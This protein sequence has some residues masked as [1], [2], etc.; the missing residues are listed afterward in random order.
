MSQIEPERLNHGI[1]EEKIRPI[2]PFWEEFW[3]QEQL[4]TDPRLQGFPDL[5]K[6]FYINQTK[7]RDPSMQELM[8]SI[9]K[10]AYSNYSPEEAHQILK[11]YMFSCVLTQYNES[12]GKKGETMTVRKKE[13]D[14][15]GNP[16]P[17]IVH[18][19]SM[20]IEAM[21]ESSANVRTNRNNSKK[22][23][24]AVTAMA[25]SGHDLVEDCRMSVEYNDE[26]GKSKKESISGRTILE[27]IRIEFPE[28]SEEVVDA[29]DSVTKYENLPPGLRKLIDESTLKAYLEQ[30]LLP[31]AGRSNLS[32]DEKNKMQK[33][34]TKAI[35]SLFKARSTHLLAFFQ[36]RQ[37]N[38]VISNTEKTE[39]SALRLKYFQGVVRSIYIKILD[40]VNNAKTGISVA[41]QIRARQLATLARILG[42]YKQSD[43]LMYLLADLKD[44]PFPQDKKIASN[45]E[46]N[47]SLYRTQFNAFFENFFK[48]QIG[49]DISVYIGPRIAFPEEGTVEPVPQAI[50]MVPSENFTDVFTFME[51]NT[52]NSELGRIIGTKPPFTF[53]PFEGILE[54]TTRIWGREGVMLRVL[55][56]DNKVVFYIRILEDKPLLS[57]YILNGYNPQDRSPEEKMFK[58]L[59]TIN[60]PADIRL[61]HAGLFYLNPEALREIKFE[62]GP[63]KHLYI[64]I[65]D[66]GFTT[67]TGL[68]NAKTLCRE[69]GLDYSH[70]VLTNFEN[71]NGH[72]IDPKNPPALPILRLREA[73]I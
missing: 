14:K 21:N 63:F 2:N 15:F 54:K 42:F 43:E 48:D 65:W 13:K 49:V 10:A 61:L 66:D 41:S 19:S 40:A 27:L 29:I 38:D 25:V 17:A 20:L 31:K 57:E 46:E 24:D 36:G 60:V 73:K 30:L 7:N 62:R 8:D 44:N 51:R 71:G 70:P 16:L 1:Q 3:N 6:Q 34:I 5:F 50:M 23:V 39:E 4:F 9:L 22:G 58:P 69:L 45:P 72:E 35:S 47:D 37:M 32:A 59:K 33:E 68:P 55:N 64:I 26:T 11:M 52:H 67:V 18:P 28:F 12:T 53:E 56:Q